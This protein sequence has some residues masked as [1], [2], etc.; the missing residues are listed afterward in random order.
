MKARVLKKLLN[1]TE[2]A[3][4]NNDDYIAVGSP[5]C[6][7]LFKVDK[8]TLEIKYALDRGGRE[9][10]TRR[11]RE[12]LF[13]WDKL[14]E[15]IDSGEIHDIINGNDEIE[16][17]LPVWFEKDGEIVMSYTDEY[18]WPNTTIEGY[19]MYNNTHFKDKKSAVKAAIGEF[20]AW[21]KLAQRRI[22][23]LETELNTK[24]EKLVWIEQ[25]LAQFKEMKKGGL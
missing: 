17:P 13:I 4:S 23:E 2:Y 7:D 11:D 22:N 20:D 21:K 18:G 25:K 9:Y 10:L 3:V 6:H 5:L 19:T 14:Q 15:L 8:K 1:D 24:K 16:N 12:L